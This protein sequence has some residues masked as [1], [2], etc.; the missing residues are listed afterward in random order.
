MVRTI[1]NVIKELIRVGAEPRY[2]ISLKY[3]SYSRD[4]NV[5]LILKALTIGAE[6]ECRRQ[7][8]KTRGLLNFR[9][10]LLPINHQLQAFNNQRTH[11][12]QKAKMIRRDFLYLT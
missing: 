2:P 4:I 12:F 10:V 9:V 7:R 6:N 5:K 3:T 11:F 1:K 8:C